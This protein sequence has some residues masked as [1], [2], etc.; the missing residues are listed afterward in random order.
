MVNP[1]KDIIERC[2]QRRKKPLQQRETVTTHWIYNKDYPHQ[3]TIYCAHKYPVLLT[4]LEQACIS[5][6]PIGREP[7]KEYSFVHSSSNIQLLKPQGMKDRSARQW[8]TSWGIQMHTGIPSELDGARW[9]DLDFTYDAICTAPDAI[10]ACI[11]AL[12]NDCCEPTVDHVK[13]RWIAFFL[14]NPEL[15]TC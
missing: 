5:F 1:L 8:G 14:Q 12:I 7:E 9:H 13:V 2:H 11:E 6:T 3:Y 10:I 4:D 15:L